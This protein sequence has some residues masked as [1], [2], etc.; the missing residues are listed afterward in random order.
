MP[1][2]RIFPVVN[3]IETATVAEAVSNVV[4]AGNRHR[5]EA[6]IVNISDP[7][8]VIYLARGQ[9]AVMGAG[10]ALTARGSS[11]RIGT[12][13]LFVGDVYGISLSGTA[14]LSIS[15]GT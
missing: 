2:P 7:T 15:E 13:N 14:A 8:E 6:D 3:S 1:D 9:A 4:L 5:V 10:I 12:N 11:Y